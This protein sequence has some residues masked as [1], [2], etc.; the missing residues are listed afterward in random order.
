MRFT[1][2][3]HMAGL[4]PASFPNCIAELQFGPAHTGCQIQPIGRSALRPPGLEPWWWVIQMRPT[5]EM[6]KETACQQVDYRLNT[7]K[8]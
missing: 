5:Q 7:P 6:G 8:W 3:C 2:G 4:Q 1:P